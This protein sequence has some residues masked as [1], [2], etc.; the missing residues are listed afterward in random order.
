MDYEPFGQELPRTGVAGYTGAN[1]LSQKFTGKER[2][3]E[4]GLDYFGAR[5]MSG[6]QGRFTSPDIPLLDQNPAYPQSW[7]LYNYVRNNPLSNLDPSGRSCVKTKT[8]NPDG[9]TSDSSAD[10]GDGKGCE[11]AGIKPDAKGGLD[12]SG[13]QVN[14]YGG[15]GAA[16]A[17]VTDALLAFGGSGSKVIDYG[18]DD[19]FTKSFQESIGMMAILADVKKNCGQESGRMFV[20]T[21]EAFVNALIDGLVGGHGFYTPNAQLG[22]FNATYQRLGGALNVTVTNPISLN[23]AAYHVTS[24]LGI[25]NPR[26]GPL[27][28][29]HQTMRIRASDPCAAQ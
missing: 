18:P 3:G 23:S 15:P 1:G 26:T 6:A 21:G 7:N 9:T 4:T 28:T 10:D 25:K 27:G 20:G 2:D 29:V 24:K 19:P 5:Y 8:V 14:V 16:D 12:A 22:A 13:Q 11:A 17:E